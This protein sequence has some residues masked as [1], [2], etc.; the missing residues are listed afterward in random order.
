MLRLP[1]AIDELKAEK[2]L[3][4]SVELRHNKYLNNL[5]LALPIEISKRLTRTRHGISLVQHSTG[6]H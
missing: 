4:P 6:V 2:E 5:A 3:P 1:K